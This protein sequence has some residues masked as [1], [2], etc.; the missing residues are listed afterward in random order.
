MWALETHK[1]AAAKCLISLKEIPQLA[2]KSSGPKTS[3]TFFTM[4][5]EAAANS[6]ALQ[7]CDKNK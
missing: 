6:D 3:F 5:H 7:E 1:E 4:G 2:S